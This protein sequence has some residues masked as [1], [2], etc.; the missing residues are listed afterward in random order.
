MESESIRVRPSEQ[1]KQEVLAAEEEA[2]GKP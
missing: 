1:R 2:A